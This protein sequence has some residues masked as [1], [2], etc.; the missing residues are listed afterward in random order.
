LLSH[1]RSGIFQQPTKQFEQKEKNVLKEPIVS[2]LH[3]AFYSYLLPSILQTFFN[4]VTPST[5][6]HSA[7]LLLSI[8]H[9]QAKSPTH[10]F[11][12]SVIK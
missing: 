2:L 10:A 7:E 12:A 1:W 11:L 6:R 8:T 3:T 5:I 9:K 4:A